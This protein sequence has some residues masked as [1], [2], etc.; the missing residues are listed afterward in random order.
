MPLT[1]HTVLRTVRSKVPPLLASG[2][3]FFIPPSLGYYDPKIPH[4]TIPLSAAALN[5]VQELIETFFAQM[6]QP[7]ENKRGGYSL[8][9][10]SDCQSLVSQLVG[11]IA[12]LLKKSLKTIHLELNDVVPYGQKG[13]KEWIFTLTGT[14]VKKN[15]S[16]GA[17]STLADDLDDL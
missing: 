9:D 4:Q 14:G 5:A 8:T 16:G 15:A 1:K 13:C 10:L 17:L 6:G 7:I 3:E 12:I 2:S 11:E